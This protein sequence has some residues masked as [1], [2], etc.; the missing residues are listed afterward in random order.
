MSALTGAGLDDLLAALARFTADALVEGEGA[1]VTRLR[2]RTALEAARLCLQRIS[3]AG[4]G[5][6]FELVA[7]D[8][9]GAVAALAGLV[10]Q[11]GTEEVLGSIFARFCIG[12]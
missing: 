12:K 8:L 11:I 2:H 5:R 9:R 7:E 1:V 6:D 10:G 3:G 4:R